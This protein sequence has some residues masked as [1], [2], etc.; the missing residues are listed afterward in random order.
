VIKVKKRPCLN[1]GS[2]GRMKKK[3]KSGFPGW[4]NL[5]IMFEKILC[6][7]SLV[8]GSLLVPKLQLQRA[9][10]VKLFCLQ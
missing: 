4:N 6:Y 8:A 3:L 9:I 7:R 1:E 5:E 10:W 2:K